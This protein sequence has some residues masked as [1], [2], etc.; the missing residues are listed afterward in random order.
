MFAVTSIGLDSVSTSLWSFSVIL[1]APVFPHSVP[2]SFVYQKASSFAIEDTNCRCPRQARTFE[3][4]LA[5]RDAESAVR[6]EATI[7]VSRDFRT[8]SVFSQLISKRGHKQ[9][10]QCN[11]NIS[12]YKKVVSNFPKE[13]MV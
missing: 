12:F 5:S 2:S 8:L 6:K 10:D 1:V 13:R 3:V 9:A 7:S 4:Y 11:N